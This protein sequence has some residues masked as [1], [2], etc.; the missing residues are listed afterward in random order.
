MIFIFILLSLILTFPRYFTDIL[1]EA[2]SGE[3]SDDDDDDD[4]EGDEAEDEENKGIWM[5][6][7]D[8]T[9]SRGFL[10]FGVKNVLK[11]K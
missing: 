5:C 10:R 6:A 1:G 11:F 8:N 2:D 3:S 4:D 9:L 7:D